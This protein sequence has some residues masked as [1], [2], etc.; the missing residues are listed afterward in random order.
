MKLSDDGKILLKG[1]NRDINEDGSFDFPAGV[2]S[3]GDDAFEGCSE[4]GASRFPKEIII[5]EES[6]F[7]KYIVLVYFLSILYP[8]HQ[9]KNNWR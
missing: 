2:T 4:I 3:I 7:Y 5:K 8:D 6:A 1:T 9:E